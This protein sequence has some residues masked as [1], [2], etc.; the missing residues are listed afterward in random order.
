MKMFLKLAYCAFSLSSLKDATMRT[1]WGFS[2]FLLKFKPFDEFFPF[3]KVIANLSLR[4][5]STPRNRVTGNGATRNSVTS[6]LTFFSEIRFLQ[7]IEWEKW[8]YLHRLVLTKISSLCL[9][10]EGHIRLRLQ[11]GNVQRKKKRERLGANAQKNRANRGHSLKPNL[12]SFSVYN[13]V[14]RIL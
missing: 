4:V 14:L 7:T 8:F 6:F 10:D 12:S 1:F 11:R 13:K 5:V 9:F 2:S 3:Q